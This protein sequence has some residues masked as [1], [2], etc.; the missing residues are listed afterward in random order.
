MA[1]ETIKFR[2]RAWLNTKQGLFARINDLSNL[3]RQTVPTF[4]A[5]TLTFAHANLYRRF[6][7][8]IKN[9]V[10]AKRRGYP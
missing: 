5:E 2:T 9:E 4:E 7:R 10:A 6:G 3:F 8:D 1:G